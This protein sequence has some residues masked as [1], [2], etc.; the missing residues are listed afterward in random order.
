MRSG[1]FGSFSGVSMD[2]CKLML[3]F[4]NLLG[5]YI[6]GEAW[7]SGEDGTIDVQSFVTLVSAFSFMQGNILKIT[8]HVVSTPLGYDCLM[9]IASVIN[10]SRQ[11]RMYDGYKAGNYSRLDGTAAKA[12]QGIGSVARQR[13]KK[14]IK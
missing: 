12:K 8:D 14:E 11:I 10:D 13:I 5:I 9:R 7:I 1:A 4:L 2:A 6:A 3:F